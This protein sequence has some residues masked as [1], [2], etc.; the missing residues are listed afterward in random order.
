M[1]EELILTDPIVTAPVSTEK[2]RVV[3]MHLD[4]EIETVI[5]T[6]PQ[7]GLVQIRLLDNHGVASSYEYLGDPAVQMMK[8]MNTANFSVNSMQK[9]VLQKL[10][11]D[12]KLPPGEVTGTPDPP[13]SDDFRRSE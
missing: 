2:Y 13:A 5:A 1:A 4:L 9:R 3:V 7:K 6:P 10:T 11:Q 8:W 12:G